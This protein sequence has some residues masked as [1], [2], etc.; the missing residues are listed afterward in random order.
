MDVAGI[1][2]SSQHPVSSRRL[3]PT[4]T[5]GEIISKSAVEVHT[6]GMWE[7]LETKMIIMYNRG[8]VL[9]ADKQNSV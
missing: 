5:L 3:V 1:G 8:N 7:F 4:A 6:S 2:K 9:E